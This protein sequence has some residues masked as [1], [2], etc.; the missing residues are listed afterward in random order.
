[1]ENRTF[2]EVKT[3]GHAHPRFVCPIVE[4]TRVCRFMNVGDFELVVVMDRAAVGIDYNPYASAL[5]GNKVYGTAYV[6]CLNNGLLTGL[7]DVQHE[8]VLAF[9]CAVDGLHA[10]EGNTQLHKYVSALALAVAAA[11]QRPINLL[12]VGLAIEETL[13]D[14]LSGILSELKSKEA[15]K[16]GT[17]EKA[18]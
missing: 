12:K 13:K 3:D 2:V 16:N 15:G 4:G 7:P 8:R 10:T 14:V 18:E 11:V 1:M 17:S 9:L 5:A 6:G